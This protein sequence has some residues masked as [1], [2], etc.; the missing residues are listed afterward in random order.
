MGHHVYRQANIHPLLSLVGTNDAAKRHVNTIEGLYFLKPVM[1]GLHAN[2]VGSL[3]FAVVFPWDSVVV[4][5][6]AKSA[7]YQISDTW[8]KSIGVSE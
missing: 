6:L 3:A 7:G 4:E 1:V 2:F 8:L 5:D